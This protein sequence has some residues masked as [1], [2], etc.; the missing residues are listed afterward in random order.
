MNTIIVIVWIGLGLFFMA[1]SYNLGLGRL[2]SAG[3]GLMPFLIGLFLLGSGLCLGYT[4]IKKSRIDKHVPNAGNPTEEASGVSLKKSIILIVSLILYA[5]VMEQLG[6][7]VATF[8]LL[9]VSF[10]ALGVKRLRA[11]AGSL[12]TVLI[13]YFVFTYLGQRFPPGILRYMGFY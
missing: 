12:V 3:P 9:S 5:L 6:F 8:L 7:V 4:A 1:Y 2:S 13:C 11:L 10:H